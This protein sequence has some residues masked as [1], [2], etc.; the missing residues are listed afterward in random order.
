[1]DEAIALGDVKGFAA[2]RDEAK[3]RGKL[4]GLGIAN[5]IEST[6]GIPRERA[7]V[8]V[9]PEGRVDVIIGTQSHGQGHETSFAQCISDWLGVDFDAVHLITRRHRSGPGRR[10]QQFRPLD[11]L[12]QRTDGLRGRRD[13][14]QGQAHRRASA[15]SGACRY[16]LPRRRFRHRRHRP[17]AA[18]FTR[19]GSRGATRMDLPEDLRGK[20]AGERDEVFK[21]AAFPY[22]THVCEVEIDPE[23]GAHRARRAMPRSTMSAPRSIR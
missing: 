22:G 7:E 23:T 10:R 1:M 18:G 5:Y 3:A 13:R 8:I 21:V 20:L 4:L 6:T 12:W 9:Q 14:R 19:R 2:R 16:R 17:A 15:R 11:A